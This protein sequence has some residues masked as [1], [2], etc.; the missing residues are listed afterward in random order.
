MRSIVDRPTDNADHTPS[1]GLLR[2]PRHPLRQGA[3]TGTRGVEAGLGEGPEQGTHLGLGVGAPG[4]V[5]STGSRCA[6]LRT[7]YVDLRTRCVDLRTRGPSR[8]AGGR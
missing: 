8:Q 6:D 7:R 5:E 1:S 3:E 2:H 4:L